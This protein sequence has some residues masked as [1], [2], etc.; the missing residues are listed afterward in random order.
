MKIT[1]NEIVASLTIIAVWICLGFVISGK[2]EDWQQD[3]TAEYDKA[4]RIESRELFEH[5]METNL[6]NAFVH[7]TMEAAEPVSY[8][9]IKGE[10]SYIRREKEVYT[11]HTR[12]VTKTRTGANGKTE[13]YTEIEEYWTWDVVHREHKKTENIFFLEH[14]FPEKKIDLP[15]ARYID[16][17]RGGVHVRY[18]YYGV[19]K[20]MTGT[21]YTKLEKGTISDDSAFWSG[22]EIAEVVDSLGKS[23]AAVIFWVLWIIALAAGVCGFYYLDNHWLNS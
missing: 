21:L 7:G 23:Y 12:T 5:G 22:K 14:K 4:A 11:M 3:K 13:T 2:I 1:K 18:V 16:T 17:I 15:G 10:Y 8:K 6:G 19:P 20:K 9:D